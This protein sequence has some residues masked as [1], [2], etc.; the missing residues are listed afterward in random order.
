MPFNAF[1]NADAGVQAFEKPR[2]KEKDG[3]EPVYTREK[4]RWTFSASFGTATREKRKGNRMLWQGKIRSEG[5]RT[6]PCE[7]REMDEFRFIGKQTQ[8]TLATEDY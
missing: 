6:W 5:L 3:D 8:W 2:E 1:E 4:K 7:M